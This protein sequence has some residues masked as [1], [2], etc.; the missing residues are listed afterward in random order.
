MKLLCIDL[1]KLFSQT[2][3]G[4]SGLYRYRV[5]DVLQATEFYNNAPQFKFIGR[6]N[7]ILSIDTDKT[8]EEDLHKSV[9]IAKEILQKQNYLLI[10]YTSYANSSSMPGHYVLFWEIKL[11][12]EKLGPG[13]MQCLIDPKLIESCCFAI[14]ESLDYV[15]R[16]CRTHDR[17]IVGTF[18][19]PIFFFTIYAYEDF[20]KGSPI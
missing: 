10:E 18:A 15:Y 13:N 19:L 6:R 5:G 7:V 17:Y 2:I 3:I 14:E 11:M 16:R 12:P 9:T 8:N 4:I 1:I 20:I